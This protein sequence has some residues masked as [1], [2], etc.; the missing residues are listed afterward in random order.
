MEDHCNVSYDSPEELKI[1][2]LAAENWDCPVV[3][4]TNVQFFE[5]LFS[6]RTSKCRKLHNIAKSVIIFDEA[7]MLPASYL[8]PCT[9]VITE[10]VTNYHCTAV[11]CTATQPSLEAFFPQQLRPVEICPD[12]QGQYA[13]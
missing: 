9:R 7:Q 6:N 12:I 1:K 10:L 11:L 4:T 13:F 2:Q 8:K 5:S 3:V